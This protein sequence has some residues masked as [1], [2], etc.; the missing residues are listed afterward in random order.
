MCHVHV[1][2][3]S[4]IGRVDHVGYVD[5]ISH[6]GYGHFYHVGQFGYVD[7]QFVCVF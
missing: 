4:P 2:Y 3:V 6:V 1:G 7:M 5:C